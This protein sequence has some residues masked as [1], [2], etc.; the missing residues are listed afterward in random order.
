LLKHVTTTRLYG[1]TCKIRLTTGQNLNFN[2]KIVQHK[3]SLSNL[4]L[5]NTML[6]THDKRYP[7]SLVACIHL[8]LNHPEC[9]TVLLMSQ[10]FSDFDNK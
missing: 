1:F 5:N 7:T 2:F 10:V 9:A 3:S 8:L 6:G 4:R